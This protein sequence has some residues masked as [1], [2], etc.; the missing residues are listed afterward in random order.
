MKA[1]PGT[2][3][4]L[5]FM[6][7]LCLSACTGTKPRSYQKSKALLDTF[8]TITVVADTEE[9]ADRAIEA[10]F[11]RL[12]RFGALINFFSPD[13][14][15]AA[16]NMNAGV[17][18]TRVSPET[19]DL[20]EKALFIAE[21][22]GGAFDP[23]IGPVMRL[24][25]FHEKT[26]PRDAEIRKNLPL[27][28]YRNVRTDRKETTVFLTRKGMLLDLGGIAKGYAADLAVETLKNRGI[29][30]GIAA[31]AG[32][33]RTFGQ[34]ADGKPWRIGIRNPRQRSEKDEIAATLPLS[35][36]AISSAGDYE[37]FF[38]KDGKRYHHIMNPAT[39]YP[40]EGTR[41][42]SVVTGLGV[43]ADGLDNAVFVLGPEKGVQLLQQLGR[44]FPVDAFILYDNGTEYTTAGLKD[45]LTHEKEH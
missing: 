41:S 24:W 32:D 17:T 7:V 31:V 22:S 43:I 13:S 1:F 30:S 28:N 27:V 45:L 25:D 37:R 15:L 8:V 19:F 2:R 33:V 40:S 4:L 16:I 3:P 6:L 20:I 39:G 44:D 35:D 36:K 21:K 9:I 18:A 10:A 12:E 14:E 11:T 23:T 34:R 29:R 38:I 26:M 42:V 5:I